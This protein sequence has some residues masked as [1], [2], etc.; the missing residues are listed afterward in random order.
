[1][2]K[3]L[4]TVVWWIW[5]MAIKYISIKYIKYK[6]NRFKKTLLEKLQYF[7][8]T[9]IVKFNKPNYKMSKK[10]KNWHGDKLKSKLINIISRSW[11]K[12]PLKNHMSFSHI[13]I[14]RECYIYIYKVW[15]VWKQWQ[16]CRSYL[17][18]GP[19]GGVLYSPESQHQYDSGA[20]VTFVSRTHIVWHVWSK[21]A[22][23]TPVS[24]IQDS[25]ENNSMG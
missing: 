1:M 8:K 6:H 9:K 23:R 20:K 7:F 24:S 4:F 15:C 22:Y 16:I 10:K 3:H 21:G 11:K 17:C 18:S 25:H 14:I 19:A 2:T 5:R 13:F 12:L